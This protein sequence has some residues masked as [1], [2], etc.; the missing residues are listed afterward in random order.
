MTPDMTPS[1]ASMSPELNK[2]FLAFNP[3]EEDRA[4]LDDRRYGLQHV[5]VWQVINVAFVRQRLHRHDWL[6]PQAGMLER[7]FSSRRLGALG[8]ELASIP[9]RASAWFIASRSQLAYHLF[10]P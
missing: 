6:V 7:V 3:R 10:L 9:S 1:G 5:W 8:S 2:H 4:V